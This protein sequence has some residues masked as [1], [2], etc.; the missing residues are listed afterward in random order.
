MIFII[1]TLYIIGVGP[2]SKDFLT[3]KAV[4]VASKVDIVIGSQRA[5]DLFDNLNKTIVFNV[6][7]LTDKLEE[8]VDL[9]LDGYDVAVLS[10]GDP[11]F[12]GVLA[13]I[14]RI[15]GEKGLDLDNIVV[16]PGI[17]SLQLAA[18][19]NHI[20][21]DSANIMTFHGRENI[22]DILNVI[23]NGNRTIALPSRKVKDMAKFLIDNGVDEN[24]VVTVCERLS[25]DDEKIVSGTLKEISES[26]FTYMCILVI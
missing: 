1:G 7:D 21:W 19:C 18:A 12:S 16:I 6:K 24:R 9:V 23:D 14:K 2:G 15:S 22:S 11:G 25:Y 26:D 3:F 13:P 5:I 20:S 17:S 10:T 8:S 4:D